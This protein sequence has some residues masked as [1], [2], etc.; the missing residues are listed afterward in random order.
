M[1]ELINIKDLLVTVELERRVVLGGY[2]SRVIKRDKHNVVTEVG[3]WQGPFVLETKSE[4]Q[5]LADEL[6]AYHTA[7]HHKQAAAELRRL[8]AVNA[9]LLGALIVMV[10]NFGPT[11]SDD[12]RGLGEARAAIKAAKG[13]A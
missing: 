4:A 12:V 1:D 11:S 6:D 10:D 5:R 8:E 2:Q 13:E 9:Q 7:P 3:D